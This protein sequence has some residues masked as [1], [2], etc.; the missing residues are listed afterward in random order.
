M[1]TSETQATAP[2]AAAPAAQ[3]AAVHNHEFSFH[4]FLS[5]INPLQYLPV[6]GTIYRAMTGDVIPEALREGG[7]LLVSGLMGG[8]IGLITSIAE[9]IAEKA[10]GIDPEKIVTAMF[11]GPAPVAAASAAPP[12]VEPVSTSAPAQASAPA[13]PRVAITPEQLAAY[14]VRPDASGASKLDGAGGADVLNGIE[15]VRLGQ[16][17]AAYAANQATPPVVKGG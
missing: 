15:L 2:P 13:V 7:S 11:N 14:G 6:V 5:A 16:A 12:A 8:P 9:T 1:I 4:D 3:T 17:S 10:T